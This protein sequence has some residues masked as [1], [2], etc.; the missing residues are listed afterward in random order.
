MKKNR[1]QRI[2]Y[3]CQHYRKNEK[4][5]Q[6]LKV[7]SICNIKRIY[8]INTNELEIKGSHSKERKDLYAKQYKIEN[9]KIIDDWEEY[10]EKYYIEM[11]KKT[12]IKK[13]IY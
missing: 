2:V 9:I 3:I 5:P 1:N 11:E 7:G 13:N 6:K 12:F 8:Y 10:K 4:L